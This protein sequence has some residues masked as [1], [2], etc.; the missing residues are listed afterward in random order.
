M[1]TQL[2]TDFGEFVFDARGDLCVS[3]AV[4]DSSLDKFV[5]S[6]R[7]GRTADSVEPLLDLSVSCRAVSADDADE[8][9]S[10]TTTEKI[11]H[12]A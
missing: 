2:P 6:R 7:E 12:A 9:H 10:V 5:E 3:F 11:D 1:I 4:E 8:L